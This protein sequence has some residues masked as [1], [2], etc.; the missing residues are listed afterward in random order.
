MSEV[1]L[2]IIFVSFP[3]FLVLVND[4]NANCA[5]LLA[6]DPTGWRPWVCVGDR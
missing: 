1:L 5:M 2:F 3:D 6:T 4:T